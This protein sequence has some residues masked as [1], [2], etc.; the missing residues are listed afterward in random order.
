[1]YVVFGATGG[2]GSALSARL[3]AQPGSSVVLVGR[4]PGKLDALKARL[5]G[6]TQ[7]QADVTDAKQASPLH[8]GHTLIHVLGWN[9]MQGWEG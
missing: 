4:E 2:I 7:L 3:A 1:M 6:T 8:D 9:E 5:P